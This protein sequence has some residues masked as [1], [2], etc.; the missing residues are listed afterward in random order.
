MLRVFL[1][2]L[3]DTVYLEWIFS[4]NNGQIIFNEINTMPGF[5]STSMYPLLCEAAGISKRE[6]VEKL[7]ESAFNRY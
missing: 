2:Q 6:L 1:R 3:E 5:T 4:K 7:I